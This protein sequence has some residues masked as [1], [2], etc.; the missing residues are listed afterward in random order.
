MKF[1]TFCYYVS[2]ILLLNFKF[3]V[4]IVLKKISKN[5]YL[6]SSSISDSKSLI[7]NRISG[8]NSIESTE[9]KSKKKVLN[10]FKVEI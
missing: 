2:T 3:S 1:F 10:K 5:H 9:T 4:Q 8:L 6:D 7:S